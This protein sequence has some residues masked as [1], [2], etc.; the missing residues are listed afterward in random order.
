M[1]NVAVSSQ[2]IGQKDKKEHLCSNQ[3]L[4][5]FAVTEH[6]TTP[7][8]KQEDLQHLTDLPLKKFLLFLHFMAKLQIP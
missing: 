8:H 5:L 6:V 1:L 2:N 7:W 4:R 3:L